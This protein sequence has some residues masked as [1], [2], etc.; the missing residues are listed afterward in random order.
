MTDGITFDQVQ[1]DNL[2][3]APLVGDSV[4]V[5]ITVTPTIGS[6]RTSTV[7]ANVVKVAGAKVW[8]LTSDGTGMIVSVQ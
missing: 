2:P 5:T 4:S 3:S 6:V 7:S 8:L 1:V